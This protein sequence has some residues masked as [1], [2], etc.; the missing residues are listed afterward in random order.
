MRRN[1]GDATIG[2]NH[3][4]YWNIENRRREN[5]RWRVI[6][7]REFAKEHLLAA[8]VRWS[9]TQIL[10]IGSAFARRLVQKMKKDKSCAVWEPKDVTNQLAPLI[11]HIWA[12]TV[13]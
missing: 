13:C 12:D 9:V 7:K 5:V 3:E 11:R 1:K 6:D 10:Q 2:M 4:N 8:T